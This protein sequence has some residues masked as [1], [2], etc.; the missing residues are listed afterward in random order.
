MAFS[1]TPLIRLSDV[2]QLAALHC[3]QEEIAAFLGV[4]LKSLQKIIAT[5]ER[6][7]ECIREG[8][9]SGKISLRRKQFF[10]AGHNA[11]MAIHLGKQLLGQ[12][13]KSQV[14]VSGPDGGPV[15]TMDYS[16]LTVDERKS[17]RAALTKAIQST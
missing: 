2:K 13:D 12:T 3:T 14:Q 8:Q 10:L 5:D 9:A 17:L 15:E 16:K 1:K 6:V 11:T 4:G 7:A